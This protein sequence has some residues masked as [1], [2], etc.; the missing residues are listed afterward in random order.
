MQCLGGRKEHI[1]GTCFLGRIRGSSALKN[2]P[3]NE[4]DAGGMGSIPGSGRSM[5]KERTAHSSILA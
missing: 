4:G 2:L 5:E 1:I 3:A